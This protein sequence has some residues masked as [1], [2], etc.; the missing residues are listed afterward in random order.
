MAARGR[1]P[2]KPV[3]PREVD[4]ELIT[5]IKGAP[6]KYHPDLCAKL[7]EVAEQGGHVPQMCAALGIKSK[8][9]FYRWLDQY[10]EFKEAYEEAKLISQAFYENVLLMGALGKIKGF[11][12]SAMAMLMN[13]KFSEE[14]KRVGTGTEINIGQ[15]NSIGSL[16]G[17]AL[18]D[19][20]KALQSKLGLLT[21]G[22]E[23]NGEGNGET[24]A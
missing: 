17:S 13:A 14:Y 5:P 18:D 3:V 10:E 15:I 8:D 19:K 23:D 22:T 20:I 21:D 24:E 9:T 11:N 16:T 6:T 7:K 1:K 4:A 12:F 2:N